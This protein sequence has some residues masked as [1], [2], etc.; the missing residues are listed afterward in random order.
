[1]KLHAFS[2]GTESISWL[3]GNCYRC[4]KDSDTANPPKMPDATWCKGQAAIVDSMFFGAEIT[5]EI[6]AILSLSDG[7]YMNGDC[8]CFVKKDAFSDPNGWRQQ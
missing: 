1:M 8:K 2:N 6:K 5:D 4:A 7:G 3:E